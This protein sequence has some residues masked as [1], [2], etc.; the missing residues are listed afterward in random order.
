[1][2]DEYERLFHLYNRDFTKKGQFVDKSKRSKNIKEAMFK[3]FGAHKTLKFAVNKL[4]EG[5]RLG[6]QGNYGGFKPLT[7]NEI[8]ANSLGVLDDSSPILKYNYGLNKLVN[9]YDS[10]IKMGIDPNKPG[11]LKL[12]D[13][14][15]NFPRK[16]Q[17][18]FDKWDKF[19]GKDVNLR[20][21]LIMNQIGGEYEEQELTD[22]EIAKLR[23]GGYVVEELPM[24]QTGEEIEPNMVHRDANW[25]AKVRAGLPIEFAN[26]NDDQIRELYENQNIVGAEPYK[27]EMI[28]SFQLPELEILP[29]RQHELPYYR[30]LP[31]HTKQIIRESNIPTPPEVIA[32]YGYD[33]WSSKHNPML[34]SALQ[35]AS[36]GPFNLYDR[37]AIPAMIMEG[38]HQA[39][40]IYRVPQ[41]L[42]VEANEWYDGDP[43]DF[44]NVNPFTESN[45]SN[46]RR[47]SNIM[48]GGKQLDEYGQEELSWSGLGAD[49]LIDPFIIAGA[50]K[51]A[52]RGVK[53]LTKKLKSQI[54]KKGYT[55]ASKNAKFFYDFERNVGDVYNKGPEATWYYDVATTA[56]DVAYTPRRLKA[57]NTNTFTPDPTK[58]YRGIGK[59][60]Y[61]D[62]L[63]KGMFRPAQSH[64][65]MP[66]IAKHAG[67][68][69]GAGETGFE[70]AS[71]YDSDYIVEL[72]RDSFMKSPTTTGYLGDNAVVAT[73]EHVPLNKGRILKKDEAG[74]YVEIT[75]EQLEKEQLAKIPKAKSATSQSFLDAFLRGDDINASKNINDVNNMANSSFAELTSLD[76]V[77]NLPEDHFLFK[78]GPGKQWQEQIFNKLGEKE[79]LERL[80]RRLV[81][82]KKD[83]MNYPDSGIPSTDFPQIQEGKQWAIDFINSSEWAQRIKDAHPGLSE[84]EILNIRKGALLRMPNISQ[85]SIRSAESAGSP[86][87]GQFGIKTDGITQKPYVAF[88]HDPLTEDH[89]LALKSLSGHEFGHSQSSGNKIRGENWHK[90]LEDSGDMMT[91]SDMMSESFPGSFETYTGLSEEQRARSIPSYMFAKESGLLE[92][93]KFTENTYNTMKKMQDADFSSV[94]SDFSSI[95]T[96][97][98]KESAINYINKVYS[99]TPTVSRSKAPK[100]TDPA[101]KGE[102]I[103]DFYDDLRVYQ[104]NKVGRK[105]PS[106]EDIDLD[107]LDAAY[108]NATDYRNTYNELKRQKA[109]EIEDFMVDYI[110]AERPRMLANNKKVTKKL[111]EYIKRL[112]TKEGTERIR[113]QILEAPEGTPIHQMLEEQV[114]RMDPTL[115]GIEESNALNNIVDNM[116]NYYKGEVKKIEAMGH[117][118]TEYIRNAE[119]SDTRA[120]ASRSKDGEVMEMYV[121]EGRLESEIDQV[122]EH[123]VGHIFGLVND[124]AMQISTG[125]DKE[126]SGLELVMTP[127]EAANAVKNN[128]GTKL[129]KD[130][131]YF[132]GTGENNNTY[133]EAT[134][135]L[136]EVRQVLL[137][138]DYIPDIYSP[139]SK[140]MIEELYTEHSLFPKHNTTMGIRLFEI[141]KD[142]DKN[143]NIITKNINKLLGIPLAV[144]AGEAAAQGSEE[145]NGQPNKQMFLN[146]RRGKGKKNYKFEEGGAY[147]ERE[148][149]PF[150]ITEL[151][152]RGHRVD[153]M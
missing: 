11:M 53:G 7:R 49:V 91:P 62:V 73:G 36:D 48:E 127:D 24:A 109:I 97:Y 133:Q 28:A 138:N 93:G 145:T 94:P 37:L 103:Y 90:A 78:N 120:W 108:N 50:N 143:M 95:S 141:I 86:H 84:S 45:K 96:H 107:D 1:M 10:F 4:E 130:I 135:Y 70:T 139:I 67:V 16:K 42:A 105:K 54:G 85:T 5:R 150:E 15:K 57:S 123:E 34:R 129:T 23:K 100:R 140:E 71:N 89:P 14:I 92:N 148:L 29:G 12:Q 63:T 32:E 106:Y 55:N 80:N 137:N 64:E 13:K 110:R 76:D 44:S 6:P 98:N 82:G 38:V 147:E 59:A 112:D 146:P 35:T 68:H 19:S 26:Y 77:L 87:G 8:G 47:P 122:L 69:Y 124:K 74:N 83:L 115:T 3:K 66:G 25:A 2:N 142:T 9:Q 88:R 118:S 131:L 46:M 104:E 134:P 151:R 79:Y 99:E 20:D 65:A 114:S 72:S 116:V 18:H 152:A 56:D 41:A 125:I 111:D 31:E 27:D 52:T 75:K 81:E 119:D 51:L 132:K 33:P 17:H 40:Q 121:G 43:Y 144:L 128:K 30:D 117:T 126:L 58:F 149:T 22:F 61:D 153:V 136:A 102:G 39:D 60:G 101:Y 113:N 21:P